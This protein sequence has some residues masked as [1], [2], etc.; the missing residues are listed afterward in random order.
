VG[1]SFWL[2]EEVLAFRTEVCSM[3]SVTQSTCIQPRQYT[4]FQ[5]HCSQNGQNYFSKTRFL[6]QDCVF[7]GDGY[8]VEKVRQFTNPKVIKSS[9]VYTKK[10]SDLLQAIMSSP[11]DYSE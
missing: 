11:Q 7:N 9:F 8:K 4:V 1:K 2:A 5:K 6:K 3:Q 10:F